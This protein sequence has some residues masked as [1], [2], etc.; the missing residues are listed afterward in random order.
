[1]V[2][3][4]P[5]CFCAFGTNDLHGFMQEVS[6]NREFLSS[7]LFSHLREDLASLVQCS[8]TQEISSIS[9]LWTTSRYGLKESAKLL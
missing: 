1:L 7:G 5:T 2:N 8:D 6:W 3:W 9:E 4:T